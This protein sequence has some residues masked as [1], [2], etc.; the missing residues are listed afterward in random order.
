MPDFNELE[1]LLVISIKKMILFLL[2]KFFVK[3]QFVYYVFM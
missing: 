1:K 2:P 3:T